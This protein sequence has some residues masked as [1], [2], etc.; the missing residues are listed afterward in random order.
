MSNKDQEILA[1]C[2]TTLTKES[3]SM[4][5]SI[6]TICKNA[7]L[8]IER[9]IRSVLNQ[10]YAEV[11]YIIIDGASTDSTMNIVNKYSTSI[12]KII[13]ET[14]H[15]IYDAMNKGIK[16]S[17]GEVIGLI[18]A[19]DWYELD[20][21]Q[22][23]V[24][25]FKC[26]DVGIVHGNVELVWSDGK[27]EAAKTDELCKLWYS[28]VVRHPATFVRRKVYEKMG[29]FDDSFKIA[30]DYDFILRCYANGIKFLYLD[31][32]LTHFSMSGVSNTDGKLCAEETDK[33]SLRYIDKSPNKYENYRIIYDRMNLRK[34]H[35]LMK[36]NELVVCG[37]CVK[38]L[39]SNN[40]ILIWGCGNWG[41]RF[42][43]F[44]QKNGYSVKG[45]IDK[46][47]KKIGT[48]V[49]NIEVRELDI[50]KKWNEKYI[51]LLAIQKA[52]KEL[53][54]GIIELRSLGIAVVKFSDM[55]KA[56]L[57]DNNCYKGDE[58]QAVNKTLA[59]WYVQ[60]DNADNNI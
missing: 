55:L 4:K 23:V 16:N 21:I 10:T 44:L 25:A 18:N 42:L 53:E 31:E 3:K 13:S 22:K 5:I 26:N 24:E 57:I 7:E 34:L 36:S 27:T 15:G 11:E 8:T 60:K 38:K 2:L 37:K 56:I 49:E 47:E 14:D 59:D 29:L 1:I 45:F 58:I 43:K 35:S 19:D 41:I 40:N 46:D 39:I 30:G 50:V 12:S 51:V 52:D 48:F 6:I 28:M 54:R 32:I 20:T 33:V 9:T 17:S